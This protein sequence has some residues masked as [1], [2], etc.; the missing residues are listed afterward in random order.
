M[1]AFIFIF[2]LILTLLSAF[3][4]LWSNNV[5][6]NAYALLLT[7]LGVA[8]LY[9]FAGADFLAVTQIM[10]YVGGILVLLIFGI[11]LTNST[12]NRLSG[13]LNAVVTQNANRIMGFG[14][15]FL[16]FGVLVWSMSKSNFIGI[17]QPHIQ[18]KS[19]IKTLGIGFMTDYVLPFEIVGIL[20]T[21]VLVGGAYLARK[22]DYV[23]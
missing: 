12:E 19:T 14:V 8:A 16:V 6:H 7:F 4:L 22:D 3:F 10:V 13:M 5:L 2:F 17:N 15:A 23:D 9:V 11:M 21:V 18:A 1:L 20:L